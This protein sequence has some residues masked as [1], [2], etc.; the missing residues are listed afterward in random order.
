MNTFTRLL[1][2]AGLVTLLAACA[3]SPDTTRPA[4]IDGPSK[5]WPASAWLVGRGQ[6][7]SRAIAQDR[8]RADLAKNFS[9]RVAETSRD[10][11]RYE[12][13]QPSG[14][15]ATGTV[16]RSARR[17]IETR[18]EQILRGVEIADL[19]R[20]PQ[21]GEYH[22]L[23]VL[24][25][26]QAAA[27]LREFIADRDAATARE[28]ALAREAADPLTAA[29]HATRAVRLQV[30]REEA[31]RLLK[32]V[33][34]SG[35]GEPSRWQLEVLRSDRDALLAR[36]RIR[37]RV[38]AD[39]VGDLEPLLA[40]A[41]ADAGFAA[42][43]DAAGYLLQAR[44]ELT[45]LIDEQGWHWYRGSLQL[46]LLDLPD[47]HPRGSVRWPVKVS[48]RDAGTARQRVLDEIGKRLQQDLRQTVISF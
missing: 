13:S 25:R 11:T 4:W 40:G 28:I 7:P 39:P 31:Q 19:W 2:C 15:S 33:D 12:G 24:D 32:V 48:A 30:S 14:K 1:A 5:R 46:E 23:A 47:Q 35:L 22:A 17:E 6:S 43:A 44:L 36:V 10:V 42:S 41:V 20:D 27:G 29:R 21:T 16:R 26:M 45:P 37:T 34:P 3:T 8:A 9:V 38:V 18:T